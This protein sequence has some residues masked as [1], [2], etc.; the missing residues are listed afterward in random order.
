MAEHLPR[1][2]AG[3]N[4]GKQVVRSACS[5]G[6]N[7]R[8]TQRAKSR[9]DFVAKMTTVL[10][11][12]DE[13]DFWLEFIERAELLPAKR[14]KALRREALELVKIVSAIRRSSLEGDG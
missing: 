1:G 14:L 9:A 3:W 7:Y 8:A 5:V 12:A 4:A 2:P 10:E 11:E 13:T 6:A